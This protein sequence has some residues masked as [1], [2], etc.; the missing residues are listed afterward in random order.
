MRKKILFALIPSIILLC[1]ML[2]GVEIWLRS[3]HISWDPHGADSGPRA[4]LNCYRPAV[5]TGYE[6]VPNTCD[7]DEDGYYRSWTEAEEPLNAYSI[8]VFGDSIADQNQWVQQATR[9]LAKNWDRPV[10]SRNAGT[11]GFDT[12]SELQLFKEKSAH[13]KADA[14][15]LQFCPNDLAVTATVVPLSDGRARIYVGWEYTE[16]PAWVL[17]SRLATYIALRFVQRNGGK[18][19]L[20]SSSSPVLQCLQQFKEMTAKRGMDFQ[21]IL[22]PPFVDDYE[23]R[24]PLVSI[25]EGDLSAEDVEAQ[26]RK[27]LQEAGI[28]FLEVR[29]IFKNR[30]ASLVEHRDHPTD[31]WHPNSRAQNFIG[32]DLGTYLAEKLQ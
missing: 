30:E 29:D 3:Q 12:C 1:S 9:T 23:D 27:V 14:L 18:D 10:I 6:A 5:T 22:F 28:E 25:K 24:T 32:E 2:I 21:V 13:I 8:L 19:I 4:H 11:P 17:R 16:V 7:R 15:V 20:R 31:M 26:S